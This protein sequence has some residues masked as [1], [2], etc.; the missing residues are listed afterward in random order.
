DHTAGIKAMAASRKYFLSLFG[1]NFRHVLYQSRNP[2]LMRPNM[3]LLSDKIIDSSDSEPPIPVYKS[4]Q[5]EPVDRKRARLLYQSR[6][7]GMLENGLLLSTFADKHLDGLNDNQLDQYDKLINE[8]SNDWEI[9]YWMTDKKPT[10]TEYDNPVME[11][12]KIHAKNEN[13][14]ERIRQPD[15]QAK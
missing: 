10:P 1:R 12:L 14:E 8:P 4:P 5:N 6:K 2:H 11:L 7:R 9:Y 15:L 13:M 3:R